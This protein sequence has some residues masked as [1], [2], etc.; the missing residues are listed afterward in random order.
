MRSR[1]KKEIEEIRKRLPR[2][3]PNP[4]AVIIRS[5]VYPGV[6]TPPRTALHDAMIA[7]AHEGFKKDGGIRRLILDTADDQTRAA[8]DE[9]VNF[10]T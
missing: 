6:P 10:A 7:A 8:S 9:F 4:I 3:D 5:F 2:P 1:W